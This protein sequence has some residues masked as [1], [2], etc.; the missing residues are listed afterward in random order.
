MKK[1]ITIIYF[2]FFSVSYSQSINIH[3]KRDLNNELKQFRVCENNATEG[4]NPCN[5]FLGNMLSTVYQINDFYSEKLGRHMR[6]I[7]ISAYLKNNNHWIL[8]GH[9]YE[10]KALSEVQK[11]ANAKKAV[12]AIYAN[13]KGIGSISLILPG[14]LKPSGS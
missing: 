1:Y 13:K 2:F 10:Q 11:Y 5:S 8:L 12:V 6:V 9:A 14:E 3:W 4:I 7:E